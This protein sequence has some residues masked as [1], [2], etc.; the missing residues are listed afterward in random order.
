MYKN[1]QQ[2]QMYKNNII[3]TACVK[4]AF[5]NMKERLCDGGGGAERSSL[6]AERMSA[7]E[8]QARSHRASRMTSDVG[9]AL[10]LFSVTAL[11][12]HHD[13]ATTNSSFGLAAVSNDALWF[14]LLFYIYFS[15][16]GAV[17]HLK[18]T[19]VFLHCHCC[20]YCKC[21]AGV[22][23]LSGAV[24]TGCVEGLWRQP[25]R[26]DVAARA[27]CTSA[28]VM[29]P[30]WK[31]R[32]ESEHMGAGGESQPAGSLCGPNG[33]NQMLRDAWCPQICDSEINS[34][35]KQ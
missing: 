28:A 15:S 4:A 11:C 30:P 6:G 20:H 34:L 8:D 16:W 5:W 18:S 35:Q 23:R 25:G 13:E 10:V 12:K 19:A 31:Q 17:R 7:Q 14:M 29:F 24:N 1:K 33:P 26:G 21:S 2:Q 27:C 9:E 32:E 22:C 3:K